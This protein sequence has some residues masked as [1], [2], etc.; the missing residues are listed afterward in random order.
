MLSSQTWVISFGNQN[1]IYVLMRS[2]LFF[3][4][5]SG[6]TF[7]VSG[8][9]RPLRQFIFSWDLAKLFVW[10]LREY[11]EVSPIILSIDPK[12]EISIQKVADT[13][14]EVMNFKGLYKFDTSCSDGQYKKTASNAK[15]RKYL[16]NFRFT[17]FKQ[18]NF[19][20]ELVNSIFSPMADLYVFYLLAIEQSVEWFLE[21]KKH[22]R[23]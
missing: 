2:F 16:P 10:V 19:Q 14:V 3:F 1:L 21:N 17:P 7:I 5:E 13:I 9:G 20:A 11:Q 18:G 15:L 8:S 22:C 4:S 6:G 23:K 12:D